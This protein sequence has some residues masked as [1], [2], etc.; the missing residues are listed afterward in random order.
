MNT[1]YAVTW[2]LGWRMKA[3]ARSA[4]GFLGGLAGSVVL[5]LIA[6]SVFL[7]ILIRL[8]IPFD[9]VPLFANLGVILLFFAYFIVHPESLR[10]YGSDSGPERILSFARIFLDILLSGPRAFFWALRWIPHGVR[11]GKMDQGGCAAVLALLHKRGARVAYRELGESV[12]VQNFPR[13]LEQL[14]LID[15][16]LFLKSEPRGLALGS[17]LKAELDRA[18]R[19]M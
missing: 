16:V 3:L 6:R 5:L 11:V 1:S 13:V 10:E 15:G 8:P 14:R 9:Y 7:S 19:E 2:M 17:E 18:K 12:K 4:G